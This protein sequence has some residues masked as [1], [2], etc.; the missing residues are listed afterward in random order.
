LVHVA[1]KAAVTAIYHSEANRT[2]QTAQPLADALSLTPIQIP[3]SNVQALVDDIFANH[4]GET[5]L[6]VG[7]SDSVPDIIAA[8]GG[9]TLSDIS[10]NEYDNLFVM[11][12]CSCSWQQPN[13]TNLQYGATSPPP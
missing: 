3:G 7:H 11:T 13:V 6:V 9:P 2:Q 10:P 8:L 5:V 4:R 1:E 12:V